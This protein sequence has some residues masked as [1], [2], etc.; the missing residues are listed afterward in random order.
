MNQEKTLKICKD[1][2]SIAFRT[3]HKKTAEEMQMV[4]AALQPKA[5]A[6]A[7]ASAVGDLRCQKTNEFQKHPKEKLIHF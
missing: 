4:L 6:I 7:M 1:I 2:Y 3:L 5:S